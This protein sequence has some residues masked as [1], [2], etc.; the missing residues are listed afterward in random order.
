MLNLTAK[1][2]QGK[3]VESSDLTAGFQLDLTSVKSKIEKFQLEQRV[4]ENL[5]NSFQLKSV[6]LKRAMV[7]I[8]GV[9]PRISKKRGSLLYRILREQK[10]DSVSKKSKLRAE[11]ATLKRELQKICPHPFVFCKEGYI[12]SRSNDYDDGYPSE[13]YCV[14]C[15]FEERAVDFR[16]NGNL[17]RVGMFFNILDDSESRIVQDEPYRQ[18]P[19]HFSREEIWVPLGAMLHA[20]EERVVKILNS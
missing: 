11:I 8:K 3:L 19:E 1:E 4:I 5:I 6:A 14:V 2:I 10:T 18:F 7:L 9:P 16:Q 12:G 17:E 13:R 15:G 20:F